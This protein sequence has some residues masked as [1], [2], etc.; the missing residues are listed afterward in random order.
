MA[1]PSTRPGSLRTWVRRRTRFNSRMYVRIGTFN[2]NNLFDRFNFEADLGQL[3]AEDRNAQTT[4]QWVFG[5]EGP[6]PG[7]P[8]PQLDAPTSSSPVFRIQKGV[9]GEL[10]QGK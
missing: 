1:G 7:D 8:P 5:G 4:Y 3:P 6:G 2:L 9:R 10:I